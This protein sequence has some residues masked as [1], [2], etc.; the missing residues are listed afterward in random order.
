[1]IQSDVVE[2]VIGMAH[3]LFYNSR[4]EA[5][6]LV[7]RAISQSPGRAA[8]S[9]STRRTSSSGEYPVLPER[10]AP[11]AHPHGLRSVH[12]RTRL[13]RRRHARRHRREGLH[14]AIP[15]YV[16]GTSGGS[17]RDEQPG[18]AEALAAWRLAA[19]TADAAI[20][21]VLDL[22]RKE[23]AAM[24][25]NLDKT[26]WKRVAFGDVVSRS[27][28]TG[29]PLRRRRRIATSRGG[30]SSPGGDSS[31]M[32]ETSATDSGFDLHL[33][34][35]TRARRSS[36]RPLVPPQGRRATFDGVVADK[37]YVMATQDE[38]TLDQRSFPDSVVGR[39]L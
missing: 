38:E 26:G 2:A 37:T 34:A 19:D 16:T 5:V 3:G 28:G 12:R 39:L 21:D 30:I 1:M 7:L 15:Q 22:L 23:A 31:R 8:F 20:T 17:E 27:T 11:A 32:A 9:S 33:R 25:L 13:R 35:S 14:L 29:R 10:A 24:T 18:V 36:S 6:V 4:M